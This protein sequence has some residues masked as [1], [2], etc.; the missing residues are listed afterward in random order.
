MRCLLDTHMALWLL[1]GSPR[2]PEQVVSLALDGAN[3]LFVSDVSV[4]E[5]AIKHMSRP[6]KLRVSGAE[7]LRKCGEAGYRSLP[8]AQEAVLEYERLDISGA[9]GVHRAPFDRMLIAQS[10][11]ANMLLVT[12]DK[13][14][15]LYGEP[16]VAVY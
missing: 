10:K 1:Q 9:A 14:L 8:L 2:T 6:D 7:F 12:H 15:A 3:E 13:S 4:W 5:V 16:L 11:A